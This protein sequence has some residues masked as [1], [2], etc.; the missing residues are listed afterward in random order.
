MTQFFHLRYTSIAHFFV[1][2]SIIIMLFAVKAAT[3]TTTKI[4]LNHYTIWNFEHVSNRSTGS[5]SGN[6]NNNHHKRRGD[7]M[8][9]V[10]FDVKIKQESISR[11]I[12]QHRDDNNENQYNLL[13][14]IENVSRL[15]SDDEIQKNDNNEINSFKIRLGLDGKCSSFYTVK[16]D[17]D[18]ELKRVIA[19]LLF[20]ESPYKMT[21]Y[22]KNRD[23]SLTDCFEQGPLGSC[24]NQIQV[25]R[26]G[27]ETL[28]HKHTVADYCDEEEPVYE[29]LIKLARPSISPDSSVDTKYFIDQTDNKLSRVEMLFKINYPSDAESVRNWYVLTFKKYE[30][31]G[32]E[33]D[34]VESLT[35]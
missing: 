33:R 5:P 3:T 35:E 2:S 4:K 16:G 23:N 32:N 22:T 34:E 25:K 20:P 19:K 7:E 30:I 18:I 21:Q 17:N 26:G 28:I 24:K 1:I 29:S 14:K 6:H 27:K 15:W 8:N 10:T 9:F 11:G 13:V 12:R 31:D